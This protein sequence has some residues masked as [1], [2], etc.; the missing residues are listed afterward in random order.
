MPKPNS[1]PSTHNSPEKSYPPQTRELLATLRGIGTIQQPLRLPHPPDTLSV[2][3]IVKNEAANI[4]DAVESFKPF[5]DEIIVNDTGSTDGTQKLLSELGVTWFQTEWR[6]DFSEARNQTLE[7]ATSSWILWLDAD[8]RIPADQAAAFLKLKTAPLDRA[9]GF[10]VIN[11]QAGRPLGTRFLQIRMFPN[12]KTLRFRYRIHEQI[13]H[14]IG[15]LGLHCFYLE[16]SIHHTGYEN[17]EMKKTKARRN[18]SLLEREKDRLA[19]E[20]SLAMSVGDSHYILEEW[21]KGIAAYQAAMEVPACREIN[22]DVY[23][24]LPNCIGR[25]LQKLGRYA[26]AMPWFDRSHGMQPGKLEPL[27]YKAECLL[28]LKRKSEASDLFT[29]LLA[30]PA[31]L[32]GTASQNDVIRAF[33][34]FHLGNIL[35]EEGDFEKCLD[36]ATRMTEAYPDVVEG[37][38]LLEKCRLKMI[39]SRS[40]LSVVMIVKNEARNIRAAVE[41]FKL[42]ADEIIV[43]DTG[44]TDGTQKLLTELG[45]T[46]FQ[47]E[48]KSD[49]SFARNQSL[50]RAN[51]QWILWLDADDILLEADALAIR[52]L[53]EQH[54]HADKA[55]GFMVKNSQDRGITGSVFNQVRLFPNRPELRFTSPVHEQILPALENAGIPVEYT[56]IRVIHTGYAG[57]EIMRGKQ[58]R[59]REI[60][61]RQIREGKEVTAVTHFSLGNACLDLSEYA[62]AMSHFERAGQSARDKGDNPHIRESAPVKI[63]ACLCY[64]GR[65]AEA[66]ARLDSPFSGSAKNGHLHPEAV[67]IKAQ[68]QAALGNAE[69]ARKEYEQLLDY[70]EGPLFIPVDFTLLKIKALRYLGE[71]WHGH[72]QGDLAV[73]LLKAG[74]ALQTGSDFRGEDLRR[75]YAQRGIPSTAPSL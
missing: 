13:I 3:M 56:G 22:K 9:F 7:R 23:H 67:L 2:V 1:I 44:S 31:L 41:S 45:V 49:F 28:A 33:A 47:S 43:N 46:W 62:E 26:E 66:L 5:A 50:D 70:S 14:S 27:Y 12:H 61:E 32:S 15:K 60:L 55:F 40:T 21:E 34:F 4:R 6:D 17:E 25:G 37:R 42:V 16:T 29:E 69:M 75:A 51:G 35:F 71:Y 11:T 52:R 30:M 38:Q 10:Q 65:Y 19:T 53:L 39:D 54:P 20:P 18:L 59:N 63:A 48:W 57:D 36:V 68:A 64:L 58:I 72:G 74:I 73:T 8:D 24:E